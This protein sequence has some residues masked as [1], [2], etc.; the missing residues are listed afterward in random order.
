MQQL[1]F[2]ITDEKSLGE[3]IH[4]LTD[5]S[6]KNRFQSLVFHMYCGPMEKE[7][8][9]RIAKELGDSFPDAGLMGVSAHAEFY[10][11]HVT[12]PMV[13]LSAMFFEQTE[14]KVYS[15]PE[16]MGSEAEAGRKVCALIDETPAVKAAEILV[17][18]APVDDYVFLQEAQK[19]RKDVKIFGGYPNGHN[20]DEDTL[21]IIHSDGVFQ[22]ALVVATYAGE[23]FHIDV[24]RTTGW[25]SI[26]RE[27]TVTKAHK[28]TM[29]EVDGMPAVKLFEK[30]LHVLPK[31]D[32]TQSTRE[33]PL[34]IK[35]GDMTMLRHPLYAT[36]AGE[37]ELAGYV[38]EGMKV[39]MSYGNPSAII[40]SVN[41]RCEE[42]REF[43]PEAILLYTC[44]MR[45]MFWNEF[46]DQEILPFE[47][48]APSTGFCT[49]GEL[50]RDLN[51]GKIMW[52]NI[53]LL[54]I[55]MREGEKKGKDLPGVMIDTSSLQGQVGLLQRLATLVQMTSMELREVVE[56]LQ[57][58]NYKLQQMATTDELTGLYNRREIENRIMKALDRAQENGREMALVMIDIDHFKHVNDT[59][60]HEAGDQILKDFADIFRKQMDE[61]RGE[62]VGRWG[63][64]EF[65]CL[66][67]DISLDEAC[68]RTQKMRQAVE[69]HHFPH[70]EK[71]TCSLG[72]IGANG[73]E[74]RKL[75][76]ARVDDMLYEAKASGRNCVKVWKE[77]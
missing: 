77:A 27:F 74:D 6:G 21:N 2:Q 26:G 47:R 60:G 13:V 10:Q 49:G 19:C 62:A 42:V 57:E 5:Y 44:T 18:A 58:A 61:E 32:F 43:E 56:S 40:E 38:D 29:I 50:D 54:S 68:E 39:L 72:L 64:E 51:T 11:G 7:W 31:D 1:I 20:M 36:A 65:F 16:I 52:H 73:S 76:F 12:E 3:S 33:F 8:L 35:E 9:E 75:L 63:G 55:A 24:A 17:S 15:F 45:K 14:V 59:Y 41:E 70:V 4:E 25:Q 66:M 23:N 46:F 71:L 30:Y 34:Y 37:L 69:T 67:P 28:N 48:I 53:T 22:N